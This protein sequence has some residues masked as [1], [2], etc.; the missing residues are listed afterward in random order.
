[1]WLV[2]GFE[3][4]RA[5]HKG[6]GHVDGRRLGGRRRVMMAATPRDARGAQLGHDLWHEDVDLLG[7]GKVRSGG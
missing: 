7:D 1:M 4:L 2:Q 6:V 5:H 3:A